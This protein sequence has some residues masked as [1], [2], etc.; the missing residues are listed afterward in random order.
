MDGEDIRTLWCFID[1]DTAPFQITVHA[2]VNIDHLKKDIKVKTGKGLRDVA[3]SSL[4]LWQVRI[5]YRPT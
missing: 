3:A 5:F 4:V 1:S 2:D